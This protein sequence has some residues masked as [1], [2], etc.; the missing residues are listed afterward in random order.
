MKEY[1][2]VNLVHELLTVDLLG[3]YLNKEYINHLNKFH[4]KS[5]RTNKLCN[6][7]KRMQLLKMHVFRLWDNEETKNY[8]KQSR[9]INRLRLLDR[10][11]NKK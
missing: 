5:K 6:R 7:N 9:R 2:K 3:S 4:Y 10:V 8:F 11:I 1:N